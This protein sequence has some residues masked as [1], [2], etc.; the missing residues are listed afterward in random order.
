MGN[1]QWAMG[2]GQW[3]MGNKECERVKIQNEKKLIEKT[4]STI[5]INMVMPNKESNNV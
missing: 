3:A 4:T 1:G 2:N 5:I